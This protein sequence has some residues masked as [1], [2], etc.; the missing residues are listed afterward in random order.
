MFSMKY[1]V[2]T[3]GRIRS[4][5]CDW[6]RVGRSGDRISV[7]ARFSAPVHTSLGAHPASCTM[8]TGSF[9]GV[10]SGRGVTLTPHSLLVPLVMRE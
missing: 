10:K 1:N 6:L 8:G 7:G 5:Y 4:R 3:V 9:P 2:N